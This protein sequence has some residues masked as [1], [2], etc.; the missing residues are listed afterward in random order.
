MQW[1]W[2]NLLKHVQIAYLAPG[3]V[4]FRQK[5][6]YICQCCSIP[7]Q[8]SELGFFLFYFVFCTLLYF[9]NFFVL[10]LFHIRLAGSS[11]FVLLYFLFFA[12]AVSDLFN[13]VSPVIL[14]WFCISYIFRTKDFSSFLLWYIFIYFLYLP[15][16]FQT[17]SIQLAEQNS[18]L[19]YFPQ[20][21]I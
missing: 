9:C 15:A 3:P 16:V 19:L 10:A 4:F 21:W 13:Q 18:R 2:L 20:C 11:I 5:P 8:S 12:G 17:I 7:F 14:Y 1:N 6:F